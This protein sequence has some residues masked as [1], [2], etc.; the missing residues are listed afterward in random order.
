[1]LNTPVA[2]HR[3][4]VAHRRRKVLCHQKVRGIAGNRVNAWAVILHSGNPRARRPWFPVLAA[5]SVG[6]HRAGLISCLPVSVKL[7][8]RRLCKRLAPFGTLPPASHFPLRRE[9]RPLLRK[10]SALLA[11]SFDSR[12]PGLAH[13][14]APLSRNPFF[15][16]S[17]IDMWPN[18]GQPLRFQ[19]PVQM[20]ALRVRTAPNNRNCDT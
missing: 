8:Q 10:T 19:S 11:F 17:S 3:S 13:S 2:Q 15:S 5:E 7:L 18:K 20:A 4:L 6:P 14:I 16:L 9:F 12:A 1:M